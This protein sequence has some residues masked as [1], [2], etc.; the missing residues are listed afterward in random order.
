MTLAWLKNLCQDE[1]IDKENHMQNNNKEYR[2]PAFFDSHL[3][4]LGIGMS[5]KILDF[6]ED[7]SIEAIL[8]KIKSAASAKAIFGRGW[9]QLDLVEK[10]ML[11]KTDL[12]R[13]CPNTPVV[14]LRVCGHVACI[15]S[16]A[17]RRLDLTF[18]N[19]QAYGKSID[20]PRGLLY[21]DALPLLDHLRDVPSISDI[22]DCFRIAE[23]MLLETGVTT[24]LSDDFSSSPLPYPLIIQALDELYRQNECHIRLIEQVNLPTASLLADYLKQGLTQKRPGNWRLGPIKLLTDGSLGAHT[25]ALRSDYHDQPGQRGILNY[26]DHELGELFDLAN[27]AKKDCHIHAIGD[28]AIEQVLSVMEQSL[29]RT[30]RS[31][32]RHAIVHAQMADYQQIKWMK[33]LGFSA[34]VQPIFLESDIAMLDARLGQRKHETYLFKTMANEGI[35]VCF[36]TDSPVESFSPFTNLRAAITRQSVKDASLGQHLPKETFQLAE[37][38]GCYGANNRYLIR[39]EKCMERDYLILDKN[40]FEIPIDELDDVHVLRTV[41]KGETVFDK[42]DRPTLSRS[43]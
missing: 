14:L 39:D 23:K 1:Q 22:K 24:I 34:I 37:A 17:F 20:Y 11:D 41:I 29:R 32:H 38:I 33:A 8:A 25:A 16:E 40:P 36:G 7:R 18:E 13:V 9:N 28:A 4:F 21:E 15:N 6:K 19:I 30:N 27:L 5:S 3:H 10:R 12:D 26:S 31:E 42:H 43:K 2:F 35:K